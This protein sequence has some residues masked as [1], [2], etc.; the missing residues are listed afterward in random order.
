[1]RL[2]RSLVAGSAVVVAT[3]LFVTGCGTASHD[4]AHS[5]LKV[6]ATTT[7]VGDLTQVVGGDDIH[8]TT[9]LS[10][11]ASAHAFEPTQADMIA[12]ADADVLVINGAGLE[13]FVDTA[14]ETSGF[15]GTIVDASSGLELDVEEHDAE[16][17]GETEAEHDEHEGANPHVWTDPRMAAQ[18]TQT[19][20]TGLAKVQPSLADTFETNAEAY[21]HKLML[22]DGWI[23]E[24]MAQIP[25]DQRLFVS[26]H[27]SLHYYLDAYDIQFV[28]SILPS[29]EDNAE[30]SLTQINELITEINALGVKAI[31]VESS[32]NP[33]TAALIAKETGATLVDKN[34]LYVDSLGAAGSGAETYIAATVHNTRVILE[35]WGVTPTELPAELQ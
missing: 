1:M 13:T 11:G 10:P 21:E 12:L 35:A 30:P 26:G 27:D 6:V 32:I 19:I 15:S 20:A 17:E 31:F 22:L 33:K 9:L 29:F 16:H 34:V 18:M 14:T 2:R 24:N 7:Q 25:E 8:L 5:E 3:G 4:A 23:A 28:G